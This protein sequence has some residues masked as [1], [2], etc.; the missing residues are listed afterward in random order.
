MTSPPP[1]APRPR[2][3]GQPAR[4]AGITRIVQ[5]D[6]LPDGVDALASADGRT[7]IVRRSLDQLG[8]KRAMR[9]VMASIRR[10]PRLALY[11]ALSLQAVRQLSRR[12]TGS[13]S[14]ASQLV[15]QVASTVGEHGS[16]L[17]V[18]VT[19]AAGTAAV[20]TVVVATATPVPTA[21]GVHRAGP[22]PAVSVI[23]SGRHKVAVAHLAPTPLHYLGVYESGVPASYAPVQ[24]F[25]AAVGMQPNIALYY[26]SWNEQFKSDFA[27]QAYDA[28]ATP[29]VQIEP[30]GVSMADIAAGRYDAYLRSY[31]AAVVN[32]GGPVII[33]FAHEPDGDWYPWGA[34]SVRPAT[35][36]AAWQ[37]VVNVFRAAGAENVIWLWTMNAQGPYSAM[38]RSWWPGGDYVTWIG[39]DGY[40]AARGDSFASVFGPGLQVAG[41]LG[42]PVLISE[43]AVGPATGDQAAAIAN[44]FTG[45]R[46]SKLLGLI[47]FDVAQVSNGLYQQDWRLEDNPA[48]VR[49][50]RQDSGY[51]SS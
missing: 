17:A 30:F 24:Q 43:T 27:V 25:Q 45:L 37:H 19:A 39:I 49:A 6:E 40:Y 23:G 51:L 33:G 2:H 22:P 38:A 44:L 18:A 29:A 7:I 12:F 10:F 46:S 20:V 21:G 8:R 3:R 50:F 4:P 42:K 41:P 35:W 47:W 14:S 13:L 28:G 9:E 5:S 31:A 48:A 16:G 32:Y 26:S 11:P 36:I 1:A 34:R 15:Q